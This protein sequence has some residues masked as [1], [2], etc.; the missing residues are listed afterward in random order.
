MTNFEREFFRPFS[1]KKEDIRRFFE[2]ALHDL[3]IAR[4]DPFPEV[5]F[6]YSFQSLIKAGLALIARK[7]KVKVRSIPGHHVKILSKMSEILGDPDLFTM[8]DAMRTRR[9]TNLYGGGRPVGEKE[10]DDYLRF[11]ETVIRR[12]KKLIEE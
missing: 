11:T 5:R 6:T 7:G 1:F 3:E 12:I 10:A 9:N 4:K 2:S 8:G